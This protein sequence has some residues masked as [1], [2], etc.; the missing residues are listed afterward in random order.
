[1][2]VTLFSSI[3]RGVTGRDS[4]GFVVGSRDHVEA[5]DNPDDSKINFRRAST[6]KA[7]PGNSSA[8]R[9]DDKEGVTNEE[10]KEELE[11]NEEC[12]GSSRYSFSSDYSSGLF[13]Y[14]NK[15]TTIQ[16]IKL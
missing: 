2:Y 12:S 1:M 7:A 11:V 13:I 3:C 8:H 5:E 16:I 10:E 6:I 15:I 9:T 14:D 4:G